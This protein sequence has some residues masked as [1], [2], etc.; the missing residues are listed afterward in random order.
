MNENSV[1]RKPYVSPYTLKDKLRMTLWW[2]ISGCLFRTSPHKFNSFRCYLLRAF[3]AKV[4]SNTFIHSKATIWFPWNLEI[5]VHSGIGF[6]ALIYNLDK[7]TIGDYSTVAH[8][9]QVNTG[10]HDFA[11]PTYKLITQPVKIGNN[12]FVGTD[13]YIAPGVL[14]GDMTIIGAK[15]VVVKSMPDN[16]ICFGHPCKPIKPRSM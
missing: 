15:S 10:S 9:C 16:M 12:V 3:G 1:W 11:D 4:G 14:I 5:G 8:R 6:D 7:V 2:F 13:C